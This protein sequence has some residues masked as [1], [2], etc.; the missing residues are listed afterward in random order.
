MV[1]HIGLAGRYFTA[2]VDKGIPLHGCVCAAQPQHTSS[3][4]LSYYSRLPVSASQL[5]SNMT[6]SVLSSVLVCNYTKEITLS[7]I[8]PADLPAKSAYTRTVKS[9]SPP[10]N[11]VT[12]RFHVGS[13]MGRVSD[14]QA[15]NPCSFFASGDDCLWDDPS[16]GT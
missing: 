7:L 11:M 12:L 16:P 14:L 1:S 2:G 6:S 10:M 15:R 4:S 9:T 13:A 3:F 5:S 8:V